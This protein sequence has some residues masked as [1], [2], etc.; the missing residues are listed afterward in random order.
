MLSPCFKFLSQHLL[1]SLPPV[2]SVDSSF[3]TTLISQVHCKLKKTDP[4]IMQYN[5]VT[6]T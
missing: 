6:T 5:Y 1:L 2:L 4:T 3:L